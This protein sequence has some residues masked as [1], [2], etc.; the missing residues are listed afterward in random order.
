[1]WPYANTAF[2]RTTVALNDDL[3]A[4]VDAVRPST[5]ASDAEALRECV[6]RSKR[7]EDAEADIADLESELQR[8]EAKAD[9][10]QRQLAAANRRIDVTNELVAEVRS[11]VSTRE[12][13]AKAGIGARAK[14]FLFG[15]P[16]SDE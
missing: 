1:M 11:D 10:L 4:H 7:L 12:R 9:D 16:D 13:K 5:D 14:W 3:A 15:M 8:A 6:R 2:M